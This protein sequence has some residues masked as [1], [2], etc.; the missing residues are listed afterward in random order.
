MK[1]L[2][3]KAASVLARTAKKVVS[4]N[5]NMSCIM[6]CT[7]VLA[8]FPLQAYATSGTISETELDSSAGI[9]LEDKASVM[10]SNSTNK[11]NLK[12]GFKT[13]S[14]NTEIA[15]MKAYR[16]RLAQK[17]E[18]YKD[19]DTDLEI[20]SQ[21]IGDDGNLY[22]TAKETTMLTIAENNVETGYS[23]NHTFVYEQNGNEWE[24]IEDRQL[25]PTGLLP[26]YQANQFV[27]NGSDGSS[28]ADVPIINE[29]ESDVPEIEASIIKPDVM[30]GDKVSTRSGY[31]YQ[32]M[33]TY[34]EKYWSYYNPAYRSFAGKGG[35]CT[36]FVSQAL[37]EGGWA[38]KSGWYKSSDNWW[39]NETNQTWS[40]VNVDY[41]GTFARSSGRCT[42][43]DNVWKLRVGDF[44]Q[45]K[46]A[47]A[48]SKT[49]SM[50]V[51]Y[52]SNN[53]PYF[54]YHSSNR[55]RRSMNQGSGTI[56]N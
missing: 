13:R 38:D 41:L 49:H 11:G 19:Y 27:Y 17:G 50:M 16:D 31:N 24:L 39:Y 53:T 18:T 52:Y 2:K 54:T 33:A 8:A 44:L 56:Y 43:L 22:V 45:V 20:L 1:S 46:A 55:Y 21:Y 48:T 37:R 28:E 40:W 51:S 25:E 35:D 5:V 26:L 36:N 30:E 23:A 12:S 4:A 32:A 3:K 10:L 14:S 15:L 6:I 47:N 9:Y 7:S 29:N 42:M 34:L